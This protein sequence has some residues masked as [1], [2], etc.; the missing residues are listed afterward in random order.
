MRRLLTA[1]E[2]RPAPIR[3]LILLGGCLLFTLIVY[4]RTTILMPGDP[5]WNGPYDH[6]KYIYMAEHPVGTFHINP[7]CWRIG[8]PFLVGKLPL[9][10]LTGFRVQAFVFA[11]STGF[12]LYYVLRYAGYSVVE[13]V[14]GVVMYFGYG[15]ATKLLISDPYSPENATFFIGLLALYFLLKEKDLSLAAAL[16]LGALVKETVILFIPLIYTIRARRIWDGRLM[17][18]TILIAT[19]AVVALLTIRALIPAY[20]NVPSYV[21]QMGPRLTE[22]QL[23]TTTHNYLDALQRVTAVRLQ[24]TPV[25][26]VR[27]LTYGNIGILWV[28]VFFGWRESG[29]NAGARTI[30]RTSNAMLL[31]RFS[32]FIALTYLGWFMALNADRRF[33]FMFPFLIMMGLNGLRSLASGWSI[34]VM[35]F[36]P[37]FLFQYLLILVR[38]TVAEAPFDLAAATFFVSLAILY[39]VR[40]RLA[41][42]SGA[43]APAGAIAPLP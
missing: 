14:L 11:L 18:R 42:S 37:V 41:K 36:I 12:L 34:D 6:H 27:E 32:P 28:L 35:W 22:V 5:V 17:W 24:E 3:G 20:N 21:A 25:N 29:T 9:P 7:S 19:P 38:P 31:I 1:F 30:A 2:E 16:L 10:V 23:G 33:A 13:S 43:L 39:T 4:F 40:D 26:I 8:L 15:A